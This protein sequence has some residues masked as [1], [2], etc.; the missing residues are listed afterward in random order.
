MKLESSMSA[1]EA[2]ALSQKECR[3]VHVRA[4]T[5]VLADLNDASDVSTF[6]EDRG[7][8]DFSGGDFGDGHGG[9]WRVYVH[10][11]D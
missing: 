5:G 10:L 2:I 7:Y 1:L 8:H 9:E 3:I 6:V 4:S 11:E